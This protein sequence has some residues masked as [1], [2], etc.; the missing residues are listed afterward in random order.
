MLFK[1]TLLFEQ[2]ANYHARRID[3]G[4]GQLLQA[5]EDILLYADGWH[6]TL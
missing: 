2:A 3:E 6:V 4:F 5:F 1:N